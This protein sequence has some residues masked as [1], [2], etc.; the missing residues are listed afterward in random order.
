MA[1]ERGGLRETMAPVRPGTVMYP[2]RIALTNVDT[3]GEP[4]AR[5]QEATKTASFTLRME[6]RREG[7]MAAWGASAHRCVVGEFEAARHT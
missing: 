3:G 6:E 4:K 7:G 2:R 1:I 5:C